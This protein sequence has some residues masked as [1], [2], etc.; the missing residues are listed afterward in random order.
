MGSSSEAVALIEHRR[1]VD[2]HFPAQRVLGGLL[3]GQSVGDRFISSQGLG[4]THVEPGKREDR[5]S[6][7]REDTFGTRHRIEEH[8]DKVRRLVILL[9]VS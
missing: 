5:K 9:Q 7:G 6:V 1:D 3:Q 4:G 2:A 8:I